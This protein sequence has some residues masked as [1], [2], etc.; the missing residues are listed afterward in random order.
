MR[1]WEERPSFSVF[2]IRPIRR[3]WRPGE[4]PPK[5]RALLCL[6][7][8]CMSNQRP[9]SRCAFDTAQVFFLF[10]T[11]IRVTKSESS[12]KTVFVSRYGCW[13]LPSWFFLWG[14]CLQSVLV[15][16]RLLNKS[17]CWLIPAPL[18]WVWRLL[19]DGGL[20]CLVGLVVTSA[21]LH[22]GYCADLGSLLTLIRLF[23]VLYYSAY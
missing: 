15:V 2:L 10:V 12:L 18:C 5:K 6:V 9:L 16:V 20:L 19:F 17:G 14:L 21:G 7:G 22:P 23:S 4:E 3:G 1:S 11:K 13:L 8:R